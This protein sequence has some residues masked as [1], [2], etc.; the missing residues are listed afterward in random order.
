MGLP[1]ALALRG[2]GVGTLA[3]VHRAALAPLLAGRDAH[4]PAAP[5]L[6]EAGERATAPGAIVSGRAEAPPAADSRA[7]PPRGPPV[8]PAATPAAGGAP[9]RD[10]A[11]AS[12]AR[13]GGAPEAAA[14]AARLA[15]QA[16]QADVLVAAVGCAGLVTGDWVKPGAVVV[17]VGINV[18]LARS[19]CAASH[20]FALAGGAAAGAAASAYQVVG[21]V[22]FGSAARVAGAISPVPGGVGPMTVAAVLH[23]TLQCARWRLG[24]R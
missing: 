15:A 16:R 17:D 3:L 21:D 24:A 8:S 23:N 13:G 11:R 6:P 18:T 5:P 22:D 9:L 19:T 20:D 14:A 4:S 10:D 12:A 1:I 2:A 7:A